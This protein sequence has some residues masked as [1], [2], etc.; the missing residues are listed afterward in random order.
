MAQRFCGCCG[1]EAGAA[2]HE[3]CQR[4]LQLEPP[5]YCGVCARRMVVQVS[6]T[7][8][9]ATCSRHGKASGGHG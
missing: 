7:G 3:G 6:P 9:T 5:R 8:W 4:A 2:P 1:L